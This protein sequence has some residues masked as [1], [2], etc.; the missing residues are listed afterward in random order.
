[1]DAEINKIAI[2]TRVSTEDQAKEGF[3][4][5]AQLDKLRSYCKARDWIIAGEYIDDGYSG[6][7]VKRPAYYQ[8][9]EE[10]DNWDILLVIKMDRIHRNSKNFMLMMED[11]KIQG[12]EFVSMTESLD[13]STAMG[14]FVMDIIQRIAQ[15]ESEQ[16]GERVYIGMEQKAKTNG[17]IL[18]FNIPYGYNYENSKLIINDNEASQVKKIFKLYL[19]GYSMKKISGMLNEKEIPTKQNKNWGSQTI[20]T[21]LKNPLYCGYLHWEDYL[22]PGD[23][24]PIINKNTFN[25]VQKT[26][27]EKNIKM[28]NK[29]K[30]YIL[31][32]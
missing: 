2:Y 15:L 20:S 31:P 24:I 16:I 5:D 22:N 9:L 27:K 29:S 23:H 21:I 4:L 18:G 26:I 30:I 19:D 11:L 14:R 10:L 28:R 25:K 13:T 12:K 1:M 7:N 32:D 6:R 17:G 8:M 3:S